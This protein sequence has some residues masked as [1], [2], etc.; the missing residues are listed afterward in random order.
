MWLE[1]PEGMDAT[2]LLP[3]AE[4]L[5]VAFAPGAR[6]CLGGGERLLR[7]AFSLYAEE[8]LREGARRL[9][10]AIASTPPA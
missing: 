2:A 5:G 8:S 10:A 1:L 9:A 6:F 7:L 4:K 3:V